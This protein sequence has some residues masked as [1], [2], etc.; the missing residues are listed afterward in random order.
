[1]NFE[2][3]KAEL[4]RIM[5]FKD[6]FDEEYFHNW[7]IEFKESI[8]LDEREFARFWFADVSFDTHDYQLSES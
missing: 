6:S 1:M 8:Y 7:Y 5:D 4:K 2:I 3:F